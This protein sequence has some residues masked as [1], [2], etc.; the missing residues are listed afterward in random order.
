MIINYFTY[1]YCT[2]GK[3]KQMEQ[4]GGAAENLTTKGNQI[5]PQIYDQ[6]QWEK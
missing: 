6:L 5:T 3:N 2:F 1:P 4:L